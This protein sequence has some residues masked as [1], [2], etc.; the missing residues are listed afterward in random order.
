[1]EVIDVMLDIVMS[2]PGRIVFS[3]FLLCLS[4]SFSGLNL[5]V[6]SLDLSSLEMYMES[7]TPEEKGTCR[8]AW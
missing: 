1:M 8:A 5:G 6:L 7:G 3:I 2:T 4:A